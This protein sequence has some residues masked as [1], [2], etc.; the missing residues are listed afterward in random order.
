MEKK[1]ILFILPM[2][3][4]P[5]ISGGHQALFNGIVA[6]HDIMNASL[7]FIVD[8][9][10]QYLDVK[11]DFEKELPN[12]TLLP[13]YQCERITDI[14]KREKVGRPWYKKAF[15]A[16][17]PIRHRHRSHPITPITFD[18]TAYWKMCTLPS[19]E[20]F[21][22]HNQ[23][24]IDSNHFDF[25]QIEMPWLM[26]LVLGLSCEGKMIFVHHELGFVRRALEMRDTPKEDYHSWMW[27]HF[28]DMNEISLLNKY[29]AVVTLSSTD[30]MKL[31][32][33]GVVK[34]LYSSMATV[35]TSLTLEENVCSAKRLTFI[36]PDVHT[37]NYEGIMWFLENC[38]KQL[39]ETD[40]EY[41]LDVIGKWSEH[42][43]LA[44][45]S[46]YE[47]VNFLGYVDDLSDE[48]KGSIMIVPINIGSGI[49]MKILEASTRG[50]PFVSTSVG[51][52]GI[53]VKDGV[54]CIIADK[55][56]DFVRGILKMQDVSLQTQFIRQARQMVKEN[57][58]LEALRANRLKIYESI[59]ND[60]KSCCEEK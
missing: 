57:F 15:H 13:C 51:A 10:Y 50:I 3:P 8:D 33:A 27:L 43:I 45:K 56:E 5:L 18:K 14:E 38:W 16:V 29:D 41:T 24:I 58:S 6:V 19:S 46:Q 42:N 28:A 7:S 44:I 36:G 60:R 31:K 54:H 49:R 9:E 39:K 59:Y 48:M 22:K 55:P 35:E 47:G 32:E 1:S 25:V 52:E 2:L 17:F 11:K 37:P 12:V 23:V 26:T 21:V 53:P 34:P 30:T 4:Y 40:S 20:D